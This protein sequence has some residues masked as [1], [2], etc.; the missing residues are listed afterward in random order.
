VSTVTTRRIIY[1]M[2]VGAAGMLACMVAVLMTMEGIRREQ[3]EEGRKATCALVR[4]MLAA[5]RE[6]VEVPMSETRK[7]VID[8]WTYIGRIA[9]C[10][11]I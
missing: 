2:T 11:G 5:Y 3:Q 10:E 4:T 6:D 9:K 8:A 7:N 1:I